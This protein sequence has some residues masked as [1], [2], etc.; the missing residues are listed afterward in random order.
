[1]KARGLVVLDKRIFENC[2]LKTFFDPVTYLYNQM[3]Q[4]EH[5]W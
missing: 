5:L 1:M 3:K 2:F 4:F